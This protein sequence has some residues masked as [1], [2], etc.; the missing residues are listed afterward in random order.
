[1]DLSRLKFI[2]VIAA[3]VM[4]LAIGALVL[5]VPQRALAATAANS[6][7]PLGLNLMNVNYYDPEQPFLNIFKTTGVSKAS[8]GWFTRTVMSGET[9]EESYLQLDSNGYPTTLV[10]SHQPQQFTAVQVLLLRNLPNS[11]AGTGLPYRA[12]QYVVLYDGQGTLGY[13]GDASLVSS[14]PGRDVINVTTPGSS[15]IMLSINA[16]DPNH[17]GNYVH[18]I[19]VVYATE[20]SLLASGNV[21]RP[22]IGRAHV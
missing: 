21:F 2:R 14:A 17:T 15:G 7:S 16:T 9:N 13:S 4:S 11:N 8:I 12:G 1:M 10:S 22:E 19:R 6:Q 3:G 5:A 20:E 18:N